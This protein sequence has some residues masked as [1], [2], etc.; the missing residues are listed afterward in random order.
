M[1]RAQVRVGM[2]LVP[3]PRSHAVRRRRPLLQACAC[4]EGERPDSRLGTS[5]H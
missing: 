1:G 4:D 5:L 2:A 3:P